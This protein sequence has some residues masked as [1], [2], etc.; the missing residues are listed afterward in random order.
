M[1]Q[2]DRKEADACAHTY[3][4][5]KLLRKPPP[6]CRTARGAA[7]DMGAMFRDDERPGAR[8]SRTPVVFYARDRRRSRQPR[9]AVRARRRIVTSNHSVRRRNLTQSVAGTST[10]FWAPL[11]LPDR[12]RK[13]LTRARFFSPSLDGGLLLLLLSRPRR[14]LDSTIRAS[15]ALIASLCR[16]IISLRAAFSARNASNS[17]AEPTA[18][19]APV[20]SPDSAV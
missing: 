7:A 4:R 17:S 2:I 12:S 15:S 16:A 5:S 11:L 10:L 19:A 3:R 14:R 20:R 9:P 18:S 1:Q 6:G 8:A 13:L